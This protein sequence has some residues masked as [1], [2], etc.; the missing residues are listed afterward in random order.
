MASLASAL[1][2]RFDDRTNITALLN[3]DVIEVIVVE[4]IQF[5]DRCV[6]QLFISKPAKELVQ[7]EADETELRKKRTSKF[8]PQATSGRSQLMLCQQLRPSRMACR[9]R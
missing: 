7:M 4:P 2:E 3:A 5:A 9:L 1:N 6:P 8:L